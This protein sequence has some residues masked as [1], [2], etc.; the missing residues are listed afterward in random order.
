VPSAEQVDNR[1]RGRA[2]DR[3]PP[4][5]S[6]Q[7]RPVDAHRVGNKAPGPWPPA[8]GSHHLRTRQQQVSPSVGMAQDRLRRPGTLPLFGNH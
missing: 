1:R 4:N 6:G 2:E 5:L 3:I 7:N 8:Q